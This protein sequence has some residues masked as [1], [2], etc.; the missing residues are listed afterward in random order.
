MGTMAYGLLFDTTNLRD[1]Q[2]RLLAGALY[3]HVFNRPPRT[4]CIAR[5]PSHVH[6][7]LSERSLPE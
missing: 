7:C 3:S 6:F 2:Q 5:V 4:H 1:T